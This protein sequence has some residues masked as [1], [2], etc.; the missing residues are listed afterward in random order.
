MCVQGIKWVH[1]EGH[2]IY[3]KIFLKNAMFCM[4]DLGH[5]QLFR[6]MMVVAQLPEDPR[7]INTEGD[8]PIPQDPEEDEVA[9]PDNWDEFDRDPRSFT[10]LLLQGMLSEPPSFDEAGP[11]TAAPTHR[12][13][14]SPDRFTFSDHP[15]RRGGRRGRRAR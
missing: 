10:N 12:Q 14:R 13:R 1:M 6:A 8:I 5:L 11:S 2:I 3:G 15:P 9:D 4:D 7:M